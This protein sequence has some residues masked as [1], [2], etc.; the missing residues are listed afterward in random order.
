MIRYKYKVV[1]KLKKN[2]T[3]YFILTEMSLSPFDGDNDRVREISRDALF[4]SIASNSMDVLNYRIDASGKRLIEDKRIDLGM[5]DKIYG[6]IQRLKTRYDHT[7]VLK[8]MYT[9]EKSEMISLNYK[10]ACVVEFEGYYEYVKYLIAYCDDKKFIVKG[11]KD[12][13]DVQKF[14][15]IDEVYNAL[16]CDMLTKFVNRKLTFASEE[17]MAY[18]M[19][20][21]CN[22]AREFLQ[23]NEK[24]CSDN[25]HK[26]LKCNSSLF[27]LDK[28]AEVRKYKC[29]YKLDIYVYP[30][31]EVDKVL[32]LTVMSSLD[33]LYKM[34]IN[35]EYD[36]SYDSYDIGDTWNFIKTLVKNQF[37]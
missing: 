22:F 21:L 5:Q 28:P 31:D 34:Y 36:D 11:I 23:N 18:N 13:T 33:G 37:R 14:L 16:D 9:P 15:D 20:N 8:W 7:C 12:P 6:V 32:A 3:D 10:A 4:Q 29:K 2:N 19:Q 25:K 26:K 35:G 24:L 1:G 17:K 27:L 30:E